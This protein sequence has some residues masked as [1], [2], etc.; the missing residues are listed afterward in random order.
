MGLLKEIFI[1]WDSQTIGTRLFTWRK[2]RLVG[3]DSEGNRYYE[4]KDSRDMKAVGRGRQRR[5][6]VVYNG[7]V[8]A[9]RIPPEWHAWIHGLTDAPPSEAPLPVKP[10]EKAHAP[11]L[12]GTPYAYRPPGSLL[13]AGERRPATGDYEAWRP[14]D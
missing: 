3:T 7:E 2:G 1:W 11:N 14:E 13:S 6:W 9:T 5:R 12:T 8:E 4:E 10:W